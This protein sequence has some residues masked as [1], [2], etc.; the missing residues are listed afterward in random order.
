LTIKDLIFGSLNLPT[1]N[2]LKA[3]DIL[4][5][6]PQPKRIIIEKDLNGYIEEVV[7]K[8]KPL[9]IELI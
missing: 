1:S 7:G 3:L 5:S 8:S 6:I 2:C 4:N 9:E